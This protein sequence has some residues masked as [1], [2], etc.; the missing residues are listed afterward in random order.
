VSDLVELVAAD[1][2][3]FFEAVHGY[4]PFPWQTRLAEQVAKDGAWPDLLD[5]PTGVGKTA[6][7]DVAVFHLALEAGRQPRRAPLRMLFVVDRR[8]IVDQAHQRARQIAE[9]LADTVAAALESGTPSVLAR[10]GRRLASL[11]REGR[12]L[13]VVALRGGMPRSDVWARSPDAPVIAISTVDQ[14]GSRLLFRGYGLSDAMKPVHAGLLGQDVLWLLDEVHL[15]EP[16]R[17]T[18]SAIARRYRGWADVALTAPFSVVEMS[19]TPGGKDLGLRFALADADREHPVLSRRLEAKKPVELA[20]DIKERAFV[21][22]CAKRVGMFIGEGTRTVGVVV[23]RV[24]TARDV[25]DALT[26]TLSGKA[27]VQLVTGRM[28]PLDRD[29]VEAA[30]TPRIGA[31]RD[32]GVESRPIVV[33][34]TQCIEAGADFDFDALVTECA[35]LDS[36]RQRFGRLNRLGERDDARG[37][38]LVRSGQNLNDPVYGDA[39]AHTSQWLMG[40]GDVDFGLSRLSL[41]EDDVLKAMLATTLDAPVL[42]PAHLDAWSQTAPIPEPDPDVSLWLHGPDRGAPE[43][44]LVWREDMSSAQIQAARAGDKAA[45]SAIAAS[46]EALPPSSPEAMSLP[47]G[48][49]RRW[50]LGMAA[51]DTA[52]VE[53]AVEEEVEDKRKEVRERD[54]ALIAWRAD[55]ASLVGAGELRPGDTLVAP[56]EY[57]GIADGNWSPEAVTATDRAEEAAMRQRGRV[58]LRLFGE[59]LGAVSQPPPRPDQEVDDRTAVR[60]WLKE[61]TGVEPWAE[62]MIQGLKSEGSRVK[63]LRVPRWSAEGAVSEGFVV[64]GRKAWSAGDDATTTDGDDG[65]HVGREIALEAHLNGVA[66]FAGDFAER[67]GLGGELA[68]DIRLAAGW[69]DIGKADPRFQRLLHGDAFKAEVAT[70][71]LAKSAVVARDREARIRAMAQSGYPRGARHEVMSVALMRDCLELRGRA[72]DWELVLHLVG[73]HHGHCRPFAPVVLDDEPLMVEAVRDGVSV[74]TPSNHRLE[75]LDSGIAERYWQLVRRYGWWGLA[76]LEAIVRLS[77]HRCSEWEQRGGEA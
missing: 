61:V 46:L 60:E 75:R 26:K 28:R 36:L 13:T 14:V 15:S 49:V 17:Q 27:D 42:L 73:S 53:G 24:Q 43:V 69:H 51:P 67:L 18:L 55:G 10:V 1:F 2:P 74:A 44:Q 30:I 62:S 23:N 3:A 33:V 22:T 21:D 41:P 54:W 40:L 71:L 34:A 11:S 7:L 35:S 58:T 66:E 9:K 38:I 29:A 56:V 76:W 70:S 48:A 64:L 65:S 72:H 32:R 52:D 63:V 5:L 25:A 68:S 16:F 39:I 57:G 47:L 4:S 37:V 6:A 59:R 50:L 19:A 12:P 31:G 8:T 45:M 20:A 77:D